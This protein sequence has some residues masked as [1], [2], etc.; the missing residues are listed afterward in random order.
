MPNGIFHQPTKN[1][2][3][4]GSRDIKVTK[5]VDAYRCRIQRM[6]NSVFRAKTPYPSNNAMLIRFSDQDSPC[7]EGPSTRHDNVT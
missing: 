7:H 1:C 5:I 4:A 3:P 6:C 2:I